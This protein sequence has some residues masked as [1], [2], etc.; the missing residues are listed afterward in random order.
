MENEINV[1][2]VDIRHEN[3][4]RYVESSNYF[5]ENP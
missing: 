5:W 1:Y 4:S 2:I 3:M